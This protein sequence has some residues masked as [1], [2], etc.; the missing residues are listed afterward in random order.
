MTKAEET[1]DDGYLDGVAL[2]L[3][4]FYTGL[5]SYFEEIARTIEGA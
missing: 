2:N 3:H 1:A 5:E 4:S